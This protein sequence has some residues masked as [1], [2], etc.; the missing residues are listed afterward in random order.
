MAEYLKKIQGIVDQLREHG[1]SET[2]IDGDAATIT[3]PDLFLETIPSDSPIKDKFTYDDLDHLDKHRADYTSARI[4]LDGDIAIETFKANEGV[5]KVKH[6]GKLGGAQA[7][8]ATTYRSTGEGK[9]TVY[10]DTVI[11][12]QTQYEDSGTLNKVLKA[13]HKSGKES[14]GEK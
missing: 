7:Y 3:R 13:M 2:K 10:A 14:L 8:E 12:T 6:A 1:G 11:V 9:A 4:H 5:T